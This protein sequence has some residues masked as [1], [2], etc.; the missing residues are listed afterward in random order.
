MIALGA[1]AIGLLAGGIGLEVA[2][3]SANTSAATDRTMLQK[4]GTSTSTCFGVTTGACADLSS[5][6]NSH[7]TDA[8]AAAGLFVGAGI[9]AVAVG[10]T[11]AVWPKSKVVEGAVIVPVI[12]PSVAGLGLTGAF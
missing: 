10:V 3:S 11:F 12:T 4:G 9:L 1:G 2:S 8:N 7:T 5:Q 6:V